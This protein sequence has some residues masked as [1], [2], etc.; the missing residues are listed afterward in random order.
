VFAAGNAPP[1]SRYSRVRIGVHNQFRIDHDDYSDEELRRDPFYQEFLR[2]VGIFWHANAVL[3]TSYGEHVELSFKRR[4]DDGPYARGD[5]EILNT[6]LPDLRA[7]SRITRHM[8]DAE[9][10]GMA[11]MLRNRGLL[12]FELDR[13]GRVLVAHGDAE[14][15]PL[16]VDIINRR[17][18]AA[19]QLCQPGLDR[20]VAM[21]MQPERDQIALAALNDADGRRYILQIHPLL[22]R[23]RDLFLAASAIAVLIERDR[24]PGYSRPSARTIAPLFGLT[25]REAEVACL[26]AEG[27]EFPAI[28]SLLGISPDTA[29]TYLKFAYDKI[30]VSRQAELSALITR[31]L[32]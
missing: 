4:T 30:G 26:R 5:A 29:R 7:A 2:P 32:N 10:R 17:M 14:G 6:M 11:Q 16:P 1:N 24:S 13:W 9:A 20:A 12:T 27:L 3:N 19:D 31:L 18:V 8:L 15:R 23:T 28:S 25:E 22:E 21:A